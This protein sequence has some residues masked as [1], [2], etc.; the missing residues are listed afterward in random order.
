VKF[1]FILIAALVLIFGVYILL[2]T[3]VAV[4]PQCGGCERAEWMQPFQAITSGRKILGPYF[5]H[6]VF[7]K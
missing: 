7:T 3:K 1:L 2:F 5:L 6:P 4:D